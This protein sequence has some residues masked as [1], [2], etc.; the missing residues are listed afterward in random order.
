MHA[1]THTHKMSRWGANQSDSR[2]LTCCFRKGVNVTTGASPFTRL[3]PN[4]ETV[5]RWFLCVCGGACVCVCTC[6]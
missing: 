5:G 2:M 3:Q 1:H 4:K 6:L